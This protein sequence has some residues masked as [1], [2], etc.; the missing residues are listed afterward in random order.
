[1]ISETVASSVLIALAVAC[2]GN[3]LDHV[4]DL[5]RDVGADHLVDIHVDAGHPEPE[6]PAAPLDL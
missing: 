5:Q 2:D 4:A 3:R 1:M 6:I